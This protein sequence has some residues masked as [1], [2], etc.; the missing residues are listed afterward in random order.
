LS[1]EFAVTDTGIGI[2]K[3]QMSQIFRPFYQADSRNSRQFQG[4]GLG[5][6]ICERLAILMG[7]SVTV[8]SEL[9][10]G[11]TFRLSITASKC[12]LP[13]VKE[14]RPGDAV[15]FN[16]LAPAKILIADDV[17]MNRELIRGYFHG[18]HHELYEAENGEQ[19][20]VLCKKYLPDVVFIDVRMPVMDGREARLRLKN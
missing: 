1:L 18:S 15:D 17:P 19:A 16:R 10:R 6:N 5:L 2:S 13:A 7:G 3:D 8:V 11:S 20:I 14:D 12:S 4:T 9:G